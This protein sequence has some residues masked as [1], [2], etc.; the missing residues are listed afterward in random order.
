MPNRFPK[1][2]PHPVRAAPLRTAMRVDPPVRRATPPV[3]SA[4]PHPNAPLRWFFV[5]VAA[6]VVA[7]LGLTVRTAIARWTQ[8]RAERQIARQIAL[9]PDDQAAALVRGLVDLDEQAIPLVTRALVD[10]RPAVADAAQQSLQEL[11]TR[12]Q[13]LPVEHSTSRV[14]ALAR[15]LAAAA[16]QVPARRRPFIRDLAAQLLIWPLDPKSTSAGETIACCELILRLPP[17]TD[18]EIRVAGAPSIRPTTVSQMPESSPQP[19]PVKLPTPL[20]SSELAMPE[21][22]AP[23]VLN[24]THPDLLPDASRE[25]PQEPK[26]FLAPRAIQID[27]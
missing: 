4:A 22:A 10:P 24:P 25:A 27:G 5:V 18:T 21:P 9:L 12:W 17:P 13:L 23:R 19:L 3:T 1:Q 8:D 20:P 15:R 16:G 14:M 7:A 11:V 6:L 26:R 2:T